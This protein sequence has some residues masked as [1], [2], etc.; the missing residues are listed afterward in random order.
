MPI[1]IFNSGERP[2]ASDFNRYFMQQHSVVKPSDES[3]VSSTTFQDDNHLFAPVDANTDYW[4][5]C[6]LFYT[7]AA[8][9]VD[10]DLKIK[11]DAPSG[12]TLDWMSDGLGSATTNSVNI[13]SRNHQT[14]ANTPSP[15]TT[16][17][18]TVSPIK[19][20][21]RVGGSAG[22]FKLTW[23]QLASTATPTSIYEGSTLIVRRLTN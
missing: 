18:D 13:L 5:W 7:G 22:T 14:L 16:G 19:G 6:I 10:G 15:G 8:E 2:S 3:V 1:R 11:W 20:L 9:P 21:L 23:A 12:S 17:G 4:I